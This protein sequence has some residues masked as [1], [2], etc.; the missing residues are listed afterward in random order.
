MLE[1]YWIVP[2]LQRGNDK[3]DVQVVTIIVIYSSDGKV[4]NKLANLEVL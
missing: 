3:N 4:A 1:V 2:T